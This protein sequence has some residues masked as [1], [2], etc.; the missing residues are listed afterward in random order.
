MMHDLMHRIQRIG[1]LLAH[2]ASIA[3][4]ASAALAQ[5]QYGFFTGE[6]SQGYNFQ[7]YPVYFLN[8]PNGTLFGYY[9]FAAGATNYLYHFD[10]GTGVYIDG[11]DASH[12]AYLD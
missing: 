4:L 8:F 10:L 7:N 6:V 3:L 5:S 2:A 1:K 12:D 11:N 9:T